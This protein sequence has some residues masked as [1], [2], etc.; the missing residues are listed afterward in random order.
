MIKEELIGKKFGR[1]TILSIE[2]NKKKNDNHLMARGRCDC[3]NETYQRLTLLINNKVKSCGC[4]S[5]EKT[6]KRNTVHGYYGTRLYNIWNG[7]LTRTK[8]KGK[9]EK[10]RY[11]GRGIKVCKDWESFKNFKK[12]SLNNGYSDKLTIDRIDNDGNYEPNNCRWTSNEVQSYN[13]SN[14]KYFLYKDKKVTFGFLHKLSGINKQCLRARLKVLT[15]EEAISTPIK[16]NIVIL[17]KD[18]KYSFKSLCDFLELPYKTYHF[19]Y[20]NKGY[21]IEELIDGANKI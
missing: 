7:M 12:W 21:K 10:K 4:L 8:Y 19:K 15:V 16:K 14:T 18:K 3:G 5:K 1:I 6:K 11:W 20:K 17:Y 2:K 13:K 9:K